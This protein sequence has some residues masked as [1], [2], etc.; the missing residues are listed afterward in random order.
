[1]SSSKNL[2]ETNS[3]NGIGRCVVCSSGSDPKSLAKDLVA[4]SPCRDQI[5]NTNTGPLCAPFLED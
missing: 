4:L 1:V 2:D 5:L 3:L